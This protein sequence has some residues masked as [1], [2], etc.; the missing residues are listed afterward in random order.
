MS[1]QRISSPGVLY[2]LVIVAAVAA[3]PAEAD[4]TT[5]LVASDLSRPVYCTS[6]PGDPRLFIIEQSGLIKILADGNVLSEPFLDL[7]ELV[8]EISGDDERGLLGIAF[9]PDYFEVRHLGFHLWRAP[10]GSDSFIRINKSLIEPD[11]EDGHVY[12]FVDEGVTLGETYAFKLEAIDRMG[13]SQ[14]FSLGSITATLSSA[15]ARSFHLGPV[16]PNPFR[17]RR[18]AATIP[19]ALEAAA[20]VSLDIDD[21]R[22]VM[23]RTL[24]NGVLEGGHHS[25]AWTAAMGTAVSPTRGSTSFGSAPVNAPKPA[26]S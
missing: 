15:S 24:L 21:V 1:G 3:A 19:V 2:R 5:T 17:T 22:G 7:Q 25:I 26:S 10:D 23:V 16:E 6:P 12:G 13:G 11:E 8:P 20:R 4:L 9:H 18:T 14:F